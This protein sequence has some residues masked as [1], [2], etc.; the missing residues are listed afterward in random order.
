ME[1]KTL[2]EREHILKF[3]E[4]RR[5]SKFL[6]TG[7]V[8]I[9][10]VKRAL[11]TAIHAPSAHNAQPWRVVVVTDRKIITRLLEEMAETWKR[12]LELDGYPDWKI[13]TLIRESMERTLRAS[14]LIVVCLTMENMHVYPDDRRNRCE[15]LMAVQSVAAFIENLLLSLHALGL[16][17]CWRCGPL[18]A[19]DAV[20]K[21]LNIPDHVEPQAFI[22]VGFPGGIRDSG[23]K[24]VEEIAFLNQWG[25]PI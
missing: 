17:A 20:R 4:S 14:L 15:Y 9:E 2:E 25:N 12:D 16:G 24:P 7:E 11:K 19:P 23:R 10:F 3:I 13:D 18:F 21:V 8:Q 22:E 6:E 5:S 1:K